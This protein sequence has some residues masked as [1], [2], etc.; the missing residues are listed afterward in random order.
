MEMYKIIIMPD[1]IG[2]IANADKWYEDKQ[3]GLGSSFKE[4]TFAAVEKLQSD[5]I[6]YKSLHRGLCRVFVNRFPYV[7]YF[8]KV[9]ERKEI[10]VFGV[11][12]MKQQR[13]LLDKR[14]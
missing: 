12:H 9:K 3:V 14:V 1:A 13:S 4:N 5:K 7:V 8:K 11:L 6:V 10:M 2:D